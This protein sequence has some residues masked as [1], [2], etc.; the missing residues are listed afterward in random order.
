MSA[1]VFFRRDISN[2]MLGV[3]QAIIET[4]QLTGEL[5]PRFMAGVR[6]AMSSVAISFGIAPDAVLPQIEPPAH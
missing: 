2:I 4:A 6:T 5:D 3:S 1:D